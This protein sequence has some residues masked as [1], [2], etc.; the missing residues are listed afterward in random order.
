MS[1]YTCIVKY[2]YVA[3]MQCVRCGVV[4]FVIF[5]VSY[6]YVIKNM[7]LLDNLPQVFF[8]IVCVLISLLS[9]C[10]NISHTCR[11]K[12]TLIQFIR[13]SISLLLNP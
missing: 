7:N 12:F 3:A 9:F 4:Y 6:F 5:H 2:F 11:L 1:C 13:L 8:L 10:C